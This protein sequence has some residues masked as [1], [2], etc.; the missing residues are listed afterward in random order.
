MAIGS[1]LIIPPGDEVFMPMS[2]DLGC[3]VGAS[4]FEVT[5]WHVR[6]HGPYGGYAAQVVGEVEEDNPAFAQAMRSPDRSL[7]IEAM[8]LEDAALEAAGTWRDVTKLPPRG[9]H[10]SL[11]L[12]IGPETE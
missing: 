4:P 12:G 3:G 10:P 11:E 7:W 6:D 8:D 1:P 5:V 9:C 2:Q